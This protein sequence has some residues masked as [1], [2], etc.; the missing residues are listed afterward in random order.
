[1]GKIPSDRSKFIY[2]QGVNNPQ[3]KACQI[4]TVKKQTIE[5]KI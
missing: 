2:K 1:M 4:L 3:A 5:V